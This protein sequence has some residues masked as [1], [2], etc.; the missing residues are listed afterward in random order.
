[1]WSFGT[2]L[3]TVRQVEEILEPIGWHAALAG[4][5]MKRG[6]SE[7]DLDI[8]IYPHCRRRGGSAR[9]NIRLVR[10]ALLRAGWTQGMSRDAL[11]CKWRSRGSLDDKW[12]EVWF[13]KGRRVDLIVLS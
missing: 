13:T 7:H 11:T 4:G 8:I 1:M 3:S 9:P 2:G 12:V 6:R 10:R 5:V